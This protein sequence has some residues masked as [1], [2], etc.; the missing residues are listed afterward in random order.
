LWAVIPD[1]KMQAPNSGSLRI[2]IARD[3]DLLFQHGRY[4]GWI[5]RNPV[6]HLVSD[7]AET[8]PGTDDVRLHPLVR[9]YLAIVMEPN[10]TRMNDDDPALRA[11]LETLGARITEVD[12]VQARAVADIVERTLEAFYPR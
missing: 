12:A 4:I 8:A 6:A 1:A 11:A 5:L 10:I 3:T 7:P 9:E 2:A